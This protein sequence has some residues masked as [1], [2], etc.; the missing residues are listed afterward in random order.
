MLNIE[1]CNKFISKTKFSH[2]TRKT[3]PMCFNFLGSSSI[4]LQTLGE[5]SGSSL[6]FWDHI[7][8]YRVFRYSV[9]SQKSL[10]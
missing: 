3:A 8:S 7:N 2:Q 10:P 1:S 5:C 9:A 4:T 6:K